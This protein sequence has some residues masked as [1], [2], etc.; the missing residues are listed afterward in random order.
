LS[1]TNEPLAFKSFV[2]PSES[3]RCLPRGHYDGI[4]FR[5]RLVATA[6]SCFGNTYN[7]RQF[8]RPRGW[9]GKL[10]E[11]FGGKFGKGE[12]VV[13]RCGTHKSYFPARVVQGAAIDKWKGSTLSGAVLQW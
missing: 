1:Q 11:N 9:S 12:W 2:L 10:W 3:L 6:A 7:F 8:K 13:K 4:R 5:F